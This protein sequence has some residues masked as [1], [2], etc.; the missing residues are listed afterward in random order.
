MLRF[1]LAQLLYPVKVFLLIFTVSSAYAVSSSEVSQ[2]LSGLVSQINKVNNDLNSQQQQQRRLAKAISDSTSAIDKSEEL[3]TQLKNQRSLDIHQLE[4]L[5]TVL[6]QLKQATDTASANLKDAIARTY[7]HLRHL[8]IDDSIIAGNDNLLHRRQKKY[9]IKILQQEQQK[10]VDLRLKLAKLDTLNDKIS[11]ELDRINKQLGITT[12]R[13]SKLQTEKEAR[14][15]QAS[16][17]QQKI[18]KEKMQLANLRQQQ[19]QLNKLLHNLLAMEATEETTIHKEGT[20]S[21]LGRI[22]TSYESNSPFLL[23]KLSKPV[24]DGVVLVKFG[25]IRGGV[26]NNGLLF[27]AHASSIH[28]ISNGRVLFT[29]SLPGFGQMIVIDNGDNYTSIYGGVIPKVAKNQ[30]VSANELIGSSGTTT[31]QPMGGVYFELRHLGKPV[32]PSKLQ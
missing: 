15:E 28:A 25:D 14:L 21:S 8:Q 1:S 12:K 10:Y 31:N 20:S 26:P 19:Q 13:A 11:A 4:E 7:K 30:H 29:G 32:N 16:E 27:K 6:P 24:A 18:S 5:E 23:R 2:D 22:H 9:L 17:L 3:L